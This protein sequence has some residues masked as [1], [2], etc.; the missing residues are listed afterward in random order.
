MNERLVVDVV[1]KTEGDSFSGQLDEYGNIVVGG[2]SYT[3]IGG[4][5]SGFIDRRGEG[6]LIRDIFVKLEDFEEFARA[7]SEN[8]V[9]I[10]PTGVD[11]KPAQS[12]STELSELLF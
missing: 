10:E 2:N 5:K 11:K 12:F 7:L 1:F 6:H 3:Y 8:D 9:E 4:F